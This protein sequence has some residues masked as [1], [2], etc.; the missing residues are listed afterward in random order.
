MQPDGKQFGEHKLLP[1]G[2]SFKRGSET[3]CLLTV[4]Y[5]PSIAKIKL[6][7]ANNH[8]DH[9]DWRPE[10]ATITRLDNSESTHF[11]INQWLSNEKSTGLAGDVRLN[12]KK[13]GTLAIERN[14]E[15]SRLEVKIA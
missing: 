7:N 8:P 4:K 5:L 14:K 15:A 6:R 12:L 1:P 10:S 9:P 11:P 3:K 13:K 2:G